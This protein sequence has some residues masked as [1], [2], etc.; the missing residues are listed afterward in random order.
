MSLSSYGNIHTQTFSDLEANSTVEANLL[1]GSGRIYSIEIDNTNNKAD[2]FL[3]IWDATG[4]SVTD[5]AHFIFRVPGGEKIP[6]LF[7]SGGQG[8][9]LS[10]GLSF[11]CVTTGGDTGSTSPVSKVPVVIKTN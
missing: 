3:K 7:G 8:V 11:A 4:P 9:A 2:S 5:A 1:S 6:Y 10:N